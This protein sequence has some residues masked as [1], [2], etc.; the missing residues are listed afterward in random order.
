MSVL[1]LLFEI[2]LILGLPCVLMA[3]IVIGTSW[4][5]S[6]VRRKGYR[7]P[8]ASLISVAWW[9][10]GALGAAIWE[11]LRGIPSGY[12]FMVIYQLRF[13]VLAVSANAALL[14]ALPR[15]NTRTF[16]PRRVRSWSKFIQCLGFACL[17]FPALAFVLWVFG[18]ADFFWVWTSLIVAVDR[19]SVV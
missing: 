19:K 16:G 18:R 12:D 7:P 6:R 14:S 5:Y 9:I 4:T 17:L 2:F 1:K 11:L 10:V 3:G 13:I 15:T 8:I